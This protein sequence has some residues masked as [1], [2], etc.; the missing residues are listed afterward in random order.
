M[1]ALGASLGTAIAFWSGSGSGSAV[2]TTGTLA[3]VEIIA[4]SGGDAP[5]TALLPGGSAD[6][7]LRVDNTNP[8]PLSIIAIA[9]NGPISAVG[10]IGACST[11][12]VS[13]VLPA[14]P[15]IT[16]SPGSNLVHLD[17]AA[18]MSLAAMNGCQ[19]A[20]FQIPVSVTFKR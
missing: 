16:V 17:N 2:V 15:L 7:V 3:P 6:V 19:G 13:I 5:S 1:V 11:T 9:L 12:G 18:S 8:Y 20:T 14:G 4:L 10:G